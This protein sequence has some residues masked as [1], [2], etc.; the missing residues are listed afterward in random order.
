MSITP[1]NKAGR[2]SEGTRRDE[3]GQ[4]DGR[5]EKMESDWHGVTE[6]MKYAEKSVEWRVEGW[7]GANT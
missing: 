7:E 2:G 6:K 4:N 1:A 5:T 3:V